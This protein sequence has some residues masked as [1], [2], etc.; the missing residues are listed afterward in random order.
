MIDA[1]AQSALLNTADKIALDWQASFAFDPGPAALG[2]LARRTALIRGDR[3]PQPMRRLVDA[4]HALMTGSVRVVVPG[5]N[6]LLPLTH[7][8]EITNAILSQLHADTE[9]RLR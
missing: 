1:H 7:M 4:L 8:T 9:R 3:S 2:I 5:A 6:Y